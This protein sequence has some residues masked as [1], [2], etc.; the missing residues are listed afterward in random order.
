M[1]QLALFVVIQQDTV[2]LFTVFPRLMLLTRRA[3]CCVMTFLK[4]HTVLHAAVVG[5]AKWWSRIVVDTVLCSLSAC[6]WL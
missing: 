1:L 3:T 4:V 5:R 2:L 6:S